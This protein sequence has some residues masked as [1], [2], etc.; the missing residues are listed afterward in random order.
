M[1]IPTKNFEKYILDFREGV[2]TSNF[3]TSTG[4]KFQNI[5]SVF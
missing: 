4:P 5:E 2:G 3:T 1:N